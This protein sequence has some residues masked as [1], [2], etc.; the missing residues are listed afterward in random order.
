MHQLAIKNFDNSR[1]HCTC[2]NYRRPTG[3]IV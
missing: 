3:K 1:M 2:E